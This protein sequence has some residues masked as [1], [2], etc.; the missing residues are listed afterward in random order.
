LP[1][2]K[3]LFG[4]CRDFAKQ[5]FSGVSHL[6]LTMRRSRIMARLRRAAKDKL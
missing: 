1:E 4:N 6:D 3:G 5:H 2:K